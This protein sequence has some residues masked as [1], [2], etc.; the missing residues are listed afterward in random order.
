MYYDQET[1]A[2]VQRSNSFSVPQARRMHPTYGPMTVE[3][4]ALELAEAKYRA[5]LNRSG[6]IYREEVYGE[7]D[8]SSSHPGIPHD[9]N[10]G[11]I[12]PL[13]YYSAPHP[14]V[15]R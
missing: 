7:V 6:V 12:P 11:V 14:S 10:Y 13:N 2:K 5:A 9:L 3:E 8:W 1:E 4:E 15:L